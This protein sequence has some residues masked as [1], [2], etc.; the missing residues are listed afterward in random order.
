MR[1][2][3]YKT[4]SQLVEINIVP[5]RAKSQKRNYAIYDYK[6]FRVH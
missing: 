1:V 2:I 4:T 3:G 5:S 6:V